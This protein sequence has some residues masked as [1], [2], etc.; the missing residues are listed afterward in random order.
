MIPKGNWDLKLINF[1]PKYLILDISWY[2]EL[3]H[4]LEW[5]YSDNNPILHPL[6]GKWIN[7]FH[8]LIGSDYDLKGQIFYKTLGIE[9]LEHNSLMRVSEKSVFSL[10]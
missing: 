1:G 10:W 5:C 6:N 8:F 3:V 7:H 4:I 9:E 2:V